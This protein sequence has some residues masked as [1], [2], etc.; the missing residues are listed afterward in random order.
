MYTYIDYT[1][2]LHLMDNRY[3][4][5]MGIWYFKSEFYNVLLDIPKNLPN[6]PCYS[7]VVRYPYIWVEDPFVET[8]GGLEV[9]LEDTLELIY[10][11]GYQEYDED[12]LAELFIS[13]FISLF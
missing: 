6:E 12:V 8:E 5:S 2:M 10:G 11:D 7:N 1:K 3:F 13:A 9:I 4:Y